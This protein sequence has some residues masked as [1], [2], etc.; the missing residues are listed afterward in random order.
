[1]TTATAPRM[2]GTEINALR[3][4]GLSELEINLRR[5]AVEGTTAYMVK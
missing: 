3:A 5:N 2:T 4:E 1:M